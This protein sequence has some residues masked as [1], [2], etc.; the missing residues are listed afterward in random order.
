[1]ATLLVALVALVPGIKEQI[2]N[3]GIFTLAEGCVIA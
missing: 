2:G 1:M 3:G